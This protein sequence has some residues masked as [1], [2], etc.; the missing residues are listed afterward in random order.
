MEEQ[1]LMGIK[2]PTNETNMPPE[3]HYP[4]DPDF[5][6]TPYEDV[7]DGT[8][9]RHG[10]GIFTFEPS[11]AD[12]QHMPGTELPDWFMANEPKGMTLLMPD[13]QEYEGT[14]SHEELGIGGLAP[15]P[16]D[17]E[18]PPM[19]EE[20]DGDELPP[21]DE[22]PDGDELP[23]MDEEPSALSQDPSSKLPA[24]GGPNSWMNK[25]SAENKAPIPTKHY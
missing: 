22:E 9:T 19:D 7:E 15:S 24:P 1:G 4:N 12:L 3:G 17:E 20:P 25:P 23:P 13:G 10:P 14:L 16:M 8:W 21:M 18:L 2:P 11:E 6:G 5:N